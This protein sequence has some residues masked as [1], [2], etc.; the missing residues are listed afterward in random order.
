MKKLFVHNYNHG[1]STLSHKHNFCITTAW[2]FFLL[3]FNIFLIFILTIFSRL[4]NIERWKFSSILT[5]RENSVKFL[6]IF[7]DF[8]W[9]FSPKILASFLWLRRGEKKIGNF[10]KT[11]FYTFPTKFFA[12]SW[13]KS[14]KLFSHLFKTFLINFTFLW[15]F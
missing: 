1:N 11:P 9:E 5:A 8:L 2:F 13:I 12:T 6:L 14:K 4:S 3:S 7:E 10:G 15:T